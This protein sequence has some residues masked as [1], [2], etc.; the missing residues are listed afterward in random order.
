VEPDPGRCAGY[1]D[2]PAGGSPIDAATAAAAKTGVER[3]DEITDWLAGSSVPIRS[4]RAAAW[5]PA[6]EIRASPWRPRPGRCTTDAAS[7]GAPTNALIVHELAHQ[8]FGDSVPIG[9]WKEI[10]LT[11][12]FASYARW[13]WSED[14]GEETAAEIA[15][16]VYSMV[17][18]ADSAF[19]QVLPRDPGPARL[20]GGTR[21]DE[22]RTAAPRGTW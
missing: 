15:D 10:W 21:A 18:P 11:E 20:F 12:G 19:W 2:T 1:R 4:A 14:Q 7:S 8:R 17:Y 16:H 3:S 9:R 22:I 5:S 6:P 13:L